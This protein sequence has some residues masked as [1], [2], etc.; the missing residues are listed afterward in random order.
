V[1]RD[2]PASKEKRKRQ[3]PAGWQ[4]AE[5][6][7]KKE[8]PRVI[9]GGAGVQR[10]AGDPEEEKRGR[11]GGG[12]QPWRPQSGKKKQERYLGRGIIRPHRSRTIGEKRG[13]KEPFIRHVDKKGGKRQEYYWGRVVYA[14]RCLTRMWGK[15][16]EKGGGRSRREREKKEEKKRLGLTSERYLV[17]PP[18]LLRRGEIHEHMFP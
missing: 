3:P 9:V 18:L 4:R 17:E 7:E 16:K 5:K 15:E 14:R 1:N 13:G 2:G 6:R 8:T 10:I 11:K 12:R